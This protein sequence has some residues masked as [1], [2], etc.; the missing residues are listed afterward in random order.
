[1]ATLNQTLGSAND[2]LKPQVLQC[3]I[4]AGPQPGQGG[5]LLELSAGGKA[6]I[7]LASGEQRSFLQDGDTVILRAFCTAPGRA[8][9]GLGEAAGTV[10]G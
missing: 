10:R 5:S 4:D 8:R 9:I 3:L 2:D 1:M 6:P 7:T